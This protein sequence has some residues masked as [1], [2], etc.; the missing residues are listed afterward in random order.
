MQR[1]VGVPGISMTYVLNKSLQKNKN[2][3][4]YLPGGICH[5]CRDIQ[6]GLQH[7]S[8]NG[9]LKCGGYCKECQFDMQALEIY[10]WEKTAVYE[11]LR[12]D[13]VGGPAQVFTKYHEKNIARVIFHVYEEKG[14]L[15][16]VVIGYD[17]NGLYLH[18]SG[19][20]MPCGKE[21]LAVNRK[22]YDQKRIAKF[23]KDVLKRKVLGL[24]RL[25]LKY[26]PSFMTSLVR[27][28][29]CL[30]FKRLL[31]APYLRK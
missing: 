15:I 13:M 27:C 9:A 28:C 31:I 24:R 26:L 6:E 30:L 20:V 5:F 29:R 11:L 18:F 8:C 4:L 16:K 14:K 7:C 25:T 21:T 1:Q 22:P 12:T 2:L 17:A 10:R 19:N 23:S 3:E